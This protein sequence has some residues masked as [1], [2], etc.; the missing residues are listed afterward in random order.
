MQKHTLSNRELSRYSRH[1]M[2]PELGLAGQEK[3]KS[4]R[5]LLIGAGG[6]GSPLGL[7]LAA[8]G[9]GAIGIVDDDLVEDSNLQRQVIYTVDDIG[10]PKVECAAR[11]LQQLNPLVKV[12]PHHLRLS[13]ENALAM[14]EPYDLIIDGT[15][16]FATRYLVNDA[17]VLLGKTNVYGS[18]YRFEGQASVFNFE[19]GP[20]Y[21]CLFPEQPPAGSVPSCAEAG[22]LGVLPAIIASIQATEA[23]KILTGIGKTLSGRLMLYDALT[24]SFREMHFPKNPDCP[25]CGGNPRIT[26]LAEYNETCETTSPAGNEISPEALHN[27]LEAGESL[28]LIDVREA[29]EREICSIEG[30]IH[31][32]LQSLADHLDDF[33][34]D[35]TLVF[36]C[37]AGGR[38]AGACEIFRQ[39]GFSQ[40]CSLAG[41]IL[42]WADKIEPGL[43]RY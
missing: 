23:V 14:V 41:G 3:L 34:K 17:C 24:L 33:P 30:S 7:Y 5:V 11:R 8:A 26:G 4:S 22:V 2:L 19:N 40:S 35:Q 18:I 21:R 16:N 27:R 39:A 25:V 10:K 9:V 28:V 12:I 32:T 37:K 43:Q 36:Y 1:I 29:Y 13:K 15:D 6:L 31:L 20:C 42:A 38:S